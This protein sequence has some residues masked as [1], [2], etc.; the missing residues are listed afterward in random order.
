MDD[1]HILV[2]SVL[3][4]LVGVF[5]WGWS[6]SSKNLP[7]SSMGSV[8]LECLHGTKGIFPP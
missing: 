7:V 8:S 2:G 3:S 6:L 5:C 1:F 4:V